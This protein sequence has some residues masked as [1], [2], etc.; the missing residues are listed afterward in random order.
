MSEKI[1]V[2]ASGVPFIIKY[3]GIFDLD[4]LYRTIHEWVV[5]QRFYFQEDEVKHKVPSPAGAEQDYLFTGWRNIN[6]YARFNIMVHIKLYDLKEVEVIKEGRRKILSKSRL[7]I[8]VSGNVELDYKNR[9]EKNK[10]LLA[11]RKFYNKYILKEGEGIIGGVWWDQLYYHLNKLT[12]VIKE[13]L[14]MESKGNAYYD[15]W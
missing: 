6:E 3:S 12:T 13:F 14:D 9:F 2:P 5:D 7:R 1:P 11:L 15:M 4:N 10:F 8:Y